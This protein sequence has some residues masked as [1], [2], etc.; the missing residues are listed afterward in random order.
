MLMTESTR[1]AVTRILAIDPGVSTGYAFGSF[2]DHALHIEDSGVIEGGTLGFKRWLDAQAYV[3][4]DKVDLI[5]SETFVIDGTI[6]PGDS[7]QIEGVIM[8][9]WPGEI[10][11]QSRSDKAALIRGEKERNAWLRERFPEVK[12]QHA[13]DAVCHLMVYAAKR[14]HHRPTLEEYWP[15]A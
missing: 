11:W 7:L 4:Y 2:D 3:L 8:A 13:L 15:R 5:L 10:V 14:L 9:L 1:L 12:S 6:A